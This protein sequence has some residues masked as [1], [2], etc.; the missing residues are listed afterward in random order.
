MFERIQPDIFLDA[1]NRFAL[2][3][4]AGVDDAFLADNLQEMDIEAAILLV[5]KQF[6]FERVAFSS[7]QDPFYFKDE[8]SEALFRL[9]GTAEP[10]RDAADE[11]RYLQNGPIGNRLLLKTAP[12]SV[13]TVG[14]GMGDMHAISSLNAVMTEEDGPRSAV[15][16][17]QAETMLRYFDDPRILSGYLSSWARL[18]V[19]NQN[20]CVMLFTTSVSGISADAASLLPVPELRNAILEAQP[21]RGSPYSLHAIP[22]PGTDEIERLFQLYEQQGIGQVVEEDRQRLAAWMAAENLPLRGMV[23]PA[24]PVGYP[25]SGDRPQPGLVRRRA[26]FDQCSGAS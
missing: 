5:L 21:R 13:Q 22:G 18:P 14:G 8:E 20:L 15:V 19:S 26:Q 16:M 11:M 25:R 23:R 6:Q 3:Y 4:G 7:P 9:E 1:G 24:S 17:V 10:V 12:V 2:L